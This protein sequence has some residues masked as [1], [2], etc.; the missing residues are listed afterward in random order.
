MYIYYAY[1]VS[2]LHLQYVIFICV[3]ACGMYVVLDVH[4]MYVL[5]IYVWYLYVLFIYVWYLYVLFIYV[6]YLYVLFIYVWYLY[7]RNK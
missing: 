2:Y 1:N 5:F 4:N 6:W 7:V 3:I